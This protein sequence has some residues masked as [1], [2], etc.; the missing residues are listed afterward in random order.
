MEQ[1]YKWKLPG[2]L[3]TETL[4]Q[5]KLIS[6]TMR[7][8]KTTVM[9]AVYYDTTDHV[10]SSLKGGLRL[11]EENERRVCCLKLQSRSEGA[12]TMR[13]EYE[14]EAPDIQTGLSILLEQHP[15][16]ELRRCLIGKELMELCRTEFIR[17]SCQLDITSHEGTCRG[18]LAIDTGKLMRETRSA[19]LSE[20]EFEYL[21]GDLSAFHSFA[22]ELERT[23]GLEKQPL[24]KL[25]RAMK[26]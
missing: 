18:E 20:L 7:E 19:P 22:A 11:R 23:F 25:A 8:Q 12:C 24:S 4:L 15:L 5:T 16:E 10:F 6:E 21:D 2:H 1:E 17:N 13:E 26:V 14:A 3:D 9:K